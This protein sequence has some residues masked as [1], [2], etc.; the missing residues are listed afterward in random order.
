ML[1]CYVMNASTTV[2][3]I[4]SFAV[5]VWFDFKRDLDFYFL[6]RL[7]TCFWRVG[8]L[9]FLGGILRGEILYQMFLTVHSSVWF[10]LLATGHFIEFRTF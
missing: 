3:G 7:Y 8:E 10:S 1:L 5:H 2:L 6:Q 9:L 4:S